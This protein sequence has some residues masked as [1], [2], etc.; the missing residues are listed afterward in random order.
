MNKTAIFLFLVYSFLFIVPVVNAEY[1]L[2]YPS[3][4]PGNKIYKITRVV[5]KLKEY[6]YF[7]NLSQA[8]YHLALSDKYLVEAKTLFEYKQYLLALDALKRSDDYFSK[9]KNIEAAKAHILVLE[10]LLRQLP[11]TFEWKPEKDDPTQL[12]ISEKLEQS[13]IIRQ[14][15]L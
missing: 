10:S 14:S 6:W 9:Q 2:P 4:M 12:P 7:G 3:F 11:P 13:I 5:D 8:K 15:S 1:V